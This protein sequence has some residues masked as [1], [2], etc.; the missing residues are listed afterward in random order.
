MPSGSPDTGCRLDLLDIDG[1]PV[2]VDLAGTMTGATG[3]KPL[4]VTLC[5]LSADG[6]FSTAA[7]T[8]CGPRRGGHRLDLDSLVCS[9][10][11][12]RPQ[13]TPLVASPET[14]PTVKVDGQGR[15]SFDLSVTG[16]TKG[17]PFWLVLGQSNNSGW[18]ASVDGHDL[19][20]PQLVDGYANGWLIDP[21]AGNVAVAL[22]WTPQRN[23][24]IA[25]AVSL[26]GVLLCLFLAI[27][28]PR[29][30]RLAVEDP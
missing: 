24:W 17:Q 18:T 20:K 16:A 26:V 23:V 25:L 7:T 11:Q 19:G 10:P 2:G 21:G 22:R 30:T 12:E 14:G 3:G 29:A 4:K 15:T 6:I 8:C 28:R 27:R 9:P 5:G 13:V 1:T